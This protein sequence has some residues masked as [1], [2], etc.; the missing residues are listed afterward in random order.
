MGVED[1][2]C[3]LWPKQVTEN[4]PI[5][6]TNLSVH[7]WP[8]HLLQANAFPAK[9]CN[10]IN[11]KR[12][13]AVK[14]SLHAQPP[15]ACR[16]A[17]FWNVS[18]PPAPILQ[19]LQEGRGWGGAIMKIHAGKIQIGQ[20]YFGTSAKKVN[21]NLTFISPRIVKPSA[22]SALSF[23]SICKVRRLFVVCEDPNASRENSLKPF[24]HRESNI[25]VSSTGLAGQYNKRQN[26]Y[27]NMSAQIEK[28]NV[29]AARHCIFFLSGILHS[30]L[31]LLSLPNRLSLHLT[32]S[33]ACVDHLRGR[34]LWLS[35]CVFKKVPFFFISL[36]NVDI[37][38]V[39]DDIYCTPNLPLMVSTKRLRGLEIIKNLWVIKEVRSHSISV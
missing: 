32:F 8:S 30:V 9:A 23:W 13:A 5:Y 28:N 34:I 11:W 27:F 25:P 19:C 18:C 16:N 36:K 15:P 26:Q 17:G 22:A 3:C 38:S 2:D 29:S 10:V 4:V 31:L 12:G 39:L 33:C 35:E 21:S 1:W 20:I 7:P 24:C 6:C 37:F 14:G